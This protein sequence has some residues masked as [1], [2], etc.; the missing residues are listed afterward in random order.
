MSPLVTSGHPSSPTQISTNS[1]QPKTSHSESSQAAPLTQISNIYTQKYK[2]SHSV[3]TSNSM[4][5]Q[6]RQKA[7]LL[8]RPLHSLTKQNPS[9][10]Q[11][12]QTIFENTSFTS[13]LD[14]NPTNTTETTVQR[15]IKEIHH[16][17]VENHI[18]SFKP[19]KIINHLFMI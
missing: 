13:N 9:R 18:Q 10:R 14:A 8:T 15:N 11:M 16:S 7:Q 1:K 5:S 17:I 12:K 2:Y 4:Q 3:P 6:L 19:N